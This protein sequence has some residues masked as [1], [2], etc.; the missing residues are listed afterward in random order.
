MVCSWDGSQYSI[1]SPDSTVWL[2]GPIPWTYHTIKDVH[3]LLFLFLFFERES[4]LRVYTG[5]VFVFFN[6]GHSVFERRD[7]LHIDNVWLD[8][9]I[10]DLS[11][12]I[13][14]YCPCNVCHTLI[15]KAA[16]HILKLAEVSNVRITITHCHT[17]N[18]ILPKYGKLGQRKSFPRKG[19]SW[20]TNQ[21]ARDSPGHKCQLIVYQSQR[22]I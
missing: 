14:Q 21:T 4:L 5:P 17:W 7:G 15:N 6:V 18:Q 19:Y 2:L 10:Y 9:T 3:W 22:Q 12:C 11:Y 8:W 20:I 1:R 13:V 16:H